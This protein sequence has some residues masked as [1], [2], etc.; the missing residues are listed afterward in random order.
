MSISVDHQMGPDYKARSRCCAVS[1]QHVCLQGLHSL[2][3][4]PV[5]TGFPKDADGHLVVGCH[6]SAA[7]DLSETL[8]THNSD[9]LSASRGL[10][11]PSHTSWAGMPPSL[12]PHQR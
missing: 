12:L 9:R 7:N 6:A 2:F 8:Q 4:K 11:P 5:A 3:V 1:D 10:L